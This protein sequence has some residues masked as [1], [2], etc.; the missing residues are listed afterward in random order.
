MEMGGSTV[1]GKTRVVEGGAIGDESLGGPVSIRERRVYTCNDRG[2]VAG[3][4]EDKA[5]RGK[6]RGRDKTLGL[7][8]EGEEKIEEY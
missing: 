1:D 3:D 8:G 2:E 6:M 5:G 7:E 4:S